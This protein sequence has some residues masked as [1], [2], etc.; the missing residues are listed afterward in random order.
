M[1]T[2]GNF[3]QPWALHIPVSSKPQQ[4]GFPSERAGL[5]HRGS[6]S[7]P[8]T[9]L[10]P[11]PTGACFCP[12][13]HQTIC[14]QEHR[15]DVSISDLVPFYWGPLR[16]Q[17]LYSQSVR[18]LLQFSQF[19]I[20]RQVRYPP[21]GPWDHFP[22]HVWT[23]KSNSAGMQD[24]GEDEV[25]V[26]ALCPHKHSTVTFCGECKHYCSECIDTHTCGNNIICEAHSE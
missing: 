7:A 15:G 18:I 9:L 2:D 22:P 6:V 20:R 26:C 23:D 14:P 19:C 1:N 25:E 13:P 4:L 16:R 17:G 5:Y 12:P 24:E 10:L 8:G 21:Y 11:F 3:I